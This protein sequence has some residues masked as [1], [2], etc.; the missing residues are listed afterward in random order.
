MA[1]GPSHLETFDVERRRRPRGDPLV[2]RRYGGPLGRAVRAVH[3]TDHAGLAEH[4]LVDPL[5][6]G[7]RER[8]PA[9]IRGDARPAGCPRGEPADVR[10]RLPA[11]GLSADDVP[12][13]RTTGAQPRPA[14]RRRALAASSHAPAD[15]R[16]EPGDPRPLRRGIPR[17]DQCLRPGL[18]DADRGARGPRP[19]AGAAGDARP[20][21]RRR[22][23]DERLRPALPAVA[24]AGRERCAVGLRG[25]RRRARQAEMGRPQR[26]RGE[27]RAQGVRD[28]SADRGPARGPGAPGAAQHDPGR[29][30]RR[31]RPITGGRVGPRPRSPQPRHHQVDGR[32]RRQGRPGRRRDGRHRPPRRRATLPLPRRARDHPAPARP[33]SEPAHPSPPRSGRAPHVRRGKPIREIVGSHTRTR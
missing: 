14:G 24:P 21:R 28:R 17:A 23:A 15:P 30:G 10:A 20:H 11:G 18:P 1:G 5:R 4:G 22:R 9:G 6:P 31:V 25:L 27:T 3:R 16:A 33:G 29:L 2:P 19:V 13:G 8:V 26:Y 7:V 12:A 32:R